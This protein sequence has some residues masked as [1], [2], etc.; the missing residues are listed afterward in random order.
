MLVAAL[1]WG[2]PALGDAPSPPGTY[3]PVEGDQA[4]W[5]LYDSL[6]ETAHGDGHTVILH[7]GDSHVAADLWTAAVRHGLQDRFGR[8]GPGFV[9][10]GRSPRRY[11]HRDVVL[12]RRGR[13]EVQWVRERSWREDGWYG[14]DGTVLLSD[15][16][17]SLVTMA[18]RP[19][20][21]YGRAW[22]EVRLLYV[23]HPAGGCLDL[24]VDGRRRVRRCTSAKRVGMGRLRLDL[25]MGA[26]SVRLRTRGRGRVAILG[27]VAS[28]GRGV[29]YSPLGVN[30]ARAASILRWDRDLLAAQMDE[31]SPQ[32]IVL[33]YGT[34]EA[35]DHDDPM[36]QYEARLREVVRRIRE[37]TPD[38]ACLLTGPTD[39]PI[40]EAMTDI[41]LPD[42]RV[43]QITEVQRRVALEW[44][45]AFWDTHRT[46]G[47][48]MSMAD[49]AAAKMAARDL[50]HL[51]TRGYARLADLFLAALLA[52]MLPHP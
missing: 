19:R 14:L 7:F 28:T 52:P 6:L 1:L 43:L 48:P 49:W 5:P 17:G 47:G 4:L 29:E 51:N 32:L 2:S 18:T 42:P 10:I 15:R 27:A 21:R 36:D 31:A 22:S 25:P 44:G 12:S 11:A 39:R 37:A 8:G 45:C 41:A 9:G 26:H 16:A 35:G 33:T 23:E 3:V 46:M 38:A 30:G 50:V 20:G 34:N 24:T 40:H 13:W